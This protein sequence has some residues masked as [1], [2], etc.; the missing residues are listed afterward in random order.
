MSIDCT[1]SFAI[2]FCIY[3]VLVTHLS[4]GSNKTYYTEPILL[5]ARCAVQGVLDSYCPGDQY[6]EASLVEMAHITQIFGN[7]T[8]LTACQP[9]QQQALG[10]LNDGLCDDTVKGIYT[11]WLGM[12]VCAAAL[13][14]CS[15]VAACAYPHFTEPTREF[16]GNSRPSAPAS[17]SSSVNGDAEDPRASAIY[18]ESD[19]RS[20]QSAND[21]VVHATASSPV[22]HAPFA[23]AV[24]AEPVDRKR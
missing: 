6:L 19:T 18:Y 24:A 7:I 20:A 1:V 8:A 12:F 4:A 5:C 23:V 9:T 21:P 17:A 13:F 11:I 14:A 10:V 3:L 15:V 16:A 22:R 2:H